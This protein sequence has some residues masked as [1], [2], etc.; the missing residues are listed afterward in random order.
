MPDQKKGW[1]AMQGF[2]ANRAMEL[3]EL[4]QAAREERLQ[5]WRQ[6][7]YEAGLKTLGSEALAKEIA[8]KMDEWIRALVRVLEA[9]GGSAGGRA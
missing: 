4:P 3:I 8:E 2:L 6:S 5:L 7:D 9:G 1:A